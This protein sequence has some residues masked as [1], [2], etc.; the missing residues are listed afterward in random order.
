M[1]SIACQ[2]DDGNAA[3]FIVTNLG[4]GDSINVCP[5]HAGA[6]FYELAKAFGA[7]PD[8]V[9]VP[10]A[11]RERAGRKAKADEAATDPDT[12]DESDEDDAADGPP[13]PDGQTTIDEHLAEMNA[14]AL[15]DDEAESLA[16]Y[17]MPIDV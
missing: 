4:D 17:G 1:S 8:A 5:A 16:S 10:P 13:V 3:L 15:S 7:V 2:A 11:P 14:D 6:A 9:P 12:G